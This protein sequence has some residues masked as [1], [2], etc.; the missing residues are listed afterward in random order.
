MSCQRDRWVASRLDIGQLQNNC[1]EVQGMTIRLVFLDMEGTI[2]AK[3][4]VGLV[5]G[6][7]QHH[8]SLW[9]RLMY[10]CGP[11]AQVD[12]A[13]NIERWERG[14]FASYFDWVAESVAILRRHG[15]TKRQFQVAIESID[16]NDGVEATIREIHSR[17]IRTVIISGGFIEQARKA[18][19]DLGIYHSHAAVD[20]FW[21]RDGHIIHCNILPSDYRGKVDYLRLM[22]REFGYRSEECAF[23]GDGKN[24]VH[25]A[26]ETGLSFAYD[27]HPE[28]QRVATHSISK[29][30]Q[31]LDHISN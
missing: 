16:Y 14:D 17:G 9:S 8:H 26:N 1:G 19:I 24:D 28:L 30:S 3:Q 11:E 12:D 7:A 20:L 2:F 25:I 18:Q 5:P 4:H 29:F 31:L 13:K 27:A 21:N 15:L 22:M 10:E 23:I 6:D